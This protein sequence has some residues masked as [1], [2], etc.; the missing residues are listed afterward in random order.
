MSL[1]HLQIVPPPPPMPTFRPGP[2]VRP[3]QRRE[4]LLALT[5]GISFATAAADRGL[6]LGVAIELA[7]ERALVFADLKLI[8]QADRFADL[9]VAAQ[10]QRFVAPLPGAYGRYQASLL[11]TRRHRLNNVE[12]DEP[13][14]VPLRFFPRILELDYDEA[15]D[16]MAI[17]EAVALELAALCSGRT[18]TE[19]ALLFAGS[20]SGG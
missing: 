2:P 6:S 3:G 20:A 5:V 19:Y 14:A 4:P 16:P 8:R 9:L 1:R 18:M 15:L 12:L 13:V 11:R 7:L 17:D 10:R